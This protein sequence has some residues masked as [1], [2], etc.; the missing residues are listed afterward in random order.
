M[1]ERK[2]TNNS[3]TKVSISDE[4]FK[5]HLGLAG[6]SFGVILSLLQVRKLDIALTITLFCFI[7]I[8]PINFLIG[9]IL[10]QINDKTTLLFTKSKIRISQAVVTIS[11]IIISVGIISLIFH[12]SMFIGFIFVVIIMLSL[13]LFYFFL[14]EIKPL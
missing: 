10:G 3:E 14:P 4:P 12:F 5:M 9:Y 6:V 7:T 13:I 2:D 8:F 1:E 11:G